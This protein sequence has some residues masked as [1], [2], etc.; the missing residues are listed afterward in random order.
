MRLAELL[1]EAIEHI[2][3]LIVLYE[4]MHPGRGYEPQVWGAK[5]WLE[6]R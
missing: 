5:R 3:E 2:E 1:D 6:A 4:Q